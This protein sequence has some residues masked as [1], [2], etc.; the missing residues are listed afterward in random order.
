MQLKTNIQ[1]ISNSPVF[2]IVAF[3]ICIAP[4]ALTYVLHHPDERH[5]TD[6]AIQMEQTTDFFTPLKANGEP[7]FL[8]PVF[9][10]W[11]VAASYKSFGISQ[12]SSRLPF[13][14]FGAILLLV[15][16]KIAFKLTQSQNTSLAAIL[17]AAANPLLILSSS[18]SIPDLPQALFFT[19]AIL[20]LTGIFTSDQPRKKDL[21]LFYMGFA[22]AFATKGIPAA[23]FLLLSA[24]FLFANPWKKYPFKTLLYWPAITTGLIIGL[25]WYVLMYIIH[26]EPFIVSF[27]NDQVGE[28]VSE[29][30]F[31]ITKNIGFGLITLIGYF[32]FWIIPASKLKLKSFFKASEISTPLRLFV[33]L[34]FLWTAFMFLL[35][36]FTVK[37]YDR[38]FLPVFPL[39]SVTIAIFL[40]SEHNPAPAKN[41]PVTRNILFF[42]TLFIFLI[43]AIIAFQ[44]EN[45]TTGIISVMFIALLLLK[46]IFLKKN[47]SLLF[48]IKGISGYTLLSIL[49]AFLLISNFALPDQATQITNW[50]TQNYTGTQAITYYGHDKIAAKI[51][52][53]S[54]G[55]ILVKC[56][57]PPQRPN[58]F[59][60]SLIIFR[61]DNPPPNT[62]NSKTLPVISTEWKSFPIHL[63]LFTR[64]PESVKQKHTTQHKLFTNRHQHNRQKAHKNTKIYLK[65]SF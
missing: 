37:F 59:S 31:R 9:T 62:P 40:F 1:S 22:L 46:I 56:V 34:T 2:W 33:A 11:M 32:I 27:F 57:A 54:R 49:G 48:F 13:L 35:S 12:F 8:K 21:W 55:S 61:E 42:A 51:R 18:R 50:L 53:A 39:I 28:R 30:H 60:D 47:R 16:Y 65:Q 3:V 23:V 44:L 15:L 58:S 17:I 45:N 5:Y 24:W 14:A 7:R 63:L 41:L 10:Y 6:A 29:D 20:G 52:V 4:L 43:S 36:I 19:I 25:W 38:Y 64:T 26:G